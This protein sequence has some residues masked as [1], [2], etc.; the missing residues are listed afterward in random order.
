MISILPSEGFAPAQAAPKPNKLTEPSSQSD[1]ASFSALVSRDGADSSADADA[2]RP[3]VDAELVVQADTADTPKQARLTQT[4]INS[5]LPADQIA[6]GSIPAEEIAAAPLAADTDVK[7]MAPPLRSGAPVAA[8]EVVLPATD[9][10]LPAD[11]IIQ[12]DA[13]SAAQTKQIQTP[14]LPGTANADL[15][16]AVKAEKEPAVKT[17]TPSGEA[18]PTTPDVAGNKV[19]RA[20]ADAFR[21]EL[22]DSA[23]ARA[24]DSLKIIKSQEGADI[25]GPETKLAKLASD[26]DLAASATKSALATLNGETRIL[27]PTTATPDALISV[28]PVASTPAPAAVSG[29]TPTAPSIPLAA[30]NEISAIILNSLKNGAE[31]R[32]QL[33]VQL[34]PPEL[35]RVAIDFKF[36]AQG[37]QQITVTSENPEALRRL[38]EL[39]FELTEALKEHG[40][41]EQNL[42]FRQQADDHS[43]SGWAHQERSGSTATFAMNDTSE[44]PAPPR[45]SNAGYTHPD[46]LDL[47]L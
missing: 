26:A 34:D 35:G 36:D 5:E 3:A 20:D 16:D 19:A 10:Q 13:D 37:L 44:A 8:V 38:R 40:L 45:R 15:S 47:T 2:E 11:R 46:R 27:T 24:D 32:E 22:P 1:D 31:P 21:N 39:H 43:P 33:I 25:A 17:I 29:L 41:S 18:V 12:S 23:A 14:I 4:L 9:P 7:Q 6:P 30:P 42:S 28:A